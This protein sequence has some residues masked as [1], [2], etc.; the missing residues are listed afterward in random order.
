MDRI[1][2]LQMGRNLLV[3]IQVD[4]QV[5]AHLENRDAVHGGGILRRPSGGS[6]RSRS[7]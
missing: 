2:I 4:M 5:A 6:R 1:P 7:A 3:T